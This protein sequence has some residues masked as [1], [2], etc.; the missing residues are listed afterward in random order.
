MIE[1]RQILSL[2][3]NNYDNGSENQENHHIGSP[4]GNQRSHY[5]GCSLGLAIK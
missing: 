5:F 4:G 1:V 3:E 2:V